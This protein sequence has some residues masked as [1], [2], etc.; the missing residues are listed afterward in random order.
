M[1]IGVIGGIFVGGI[2]LGYFASLVHDEPLRS[3]ASMADDI[4][5]YSETS[6]IYFANDVYL[7]DIRSDLYREEV[8]LDNISPTL[9]DA[10]IA[11]EDEYFHEHEGVVPKA[12]LRA[13]AQEFLN[14]SVQTGGSTLTQQLIKNQILT[15]EVSFDRKAK[16][17][18]LAMRLE[19]Y[20]TKDEIIEAYLNIIPY[21]RNSSGRNI[22]GIQTASKGIFG[23][24]ASELTLPQA[25]YLAGS[26][27]GLPLT[28]LL[29]LKEN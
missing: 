1:I 9:V 27:R 29:Q 28:H 16:E 6:S 11:T 3:E 21:G 7:G 10:V 24:N 23:V 17:I 15:D 8:K 12:I 20:F 13:T 18:L 2:G 5:N 14:S 26:H 19:N 22:A 4:Y 25:A